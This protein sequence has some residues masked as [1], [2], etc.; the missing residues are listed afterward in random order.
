MAKEKNKHTGLK[1][2]IVL[3]AT[4]MILLLLGAIFLTIVAVAYDGMLGLLFAIPVIVLLI[5][6]VDT[7]MENF[8]C[9]LELYK[10]F[11]LYVEKEEQERLERELFERDE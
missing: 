8:Q 11:D 10:E 1:A 6:K 3:L 7:D 5:I 9:L 2:R 4:T